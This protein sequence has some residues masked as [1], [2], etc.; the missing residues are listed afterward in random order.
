MSNTVKAKSKG[1]TNVAVF[2]NSRPLHGKTIDDGKE[3]PQIIKLYDFT[4]G[5]TDI[6]DQ[7]NDYYTVQSKSLRWVMVALSFMLDT[8]RVN[9]KNV[10]CLKNQTEIL[11]ES[12]YNLS[13]GNWLK[14]WLCH[15]C[16][17]EV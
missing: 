13:F 3:K 16:R 1:K 5:G 4:K 12:L 11:K 15:M 10:W 6:V 7:L 14:G 17:T 9:R 8:V 2:S